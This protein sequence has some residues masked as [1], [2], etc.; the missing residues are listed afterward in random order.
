MYRKKRTYLYL[1]VI[2]TVT[3]L[4]I[5][6][7]PSTYAL[8]INQQQ[9][10]DNYIIVDKNNGDFSSIQE[11]I[12]YA[13]SGSTIYVKKGVYNEIIDVYKSI[14]L[15]GEDKESTLINPVS[16][17]N[18]YAVSLGA[19]NIKL[20]NF[21][22]KNGAPGLYASALKIIS[23]YCEIENCDLFE[24][25]IGISI[26]SS[27]NIIKNCEFWNCTDEGI[28][29][30]GWMDNG[31]IQNTIENCI[32]RNNCDGIELQYASQNIIR[33][34]EFFDNTH[35]GIDAIAS[36]N[37]R[38]Q[39]IDCIIKNNRVN[40]IYLSSSFGNKIIDCIVS[41]NQDGNIVM[42]KYSLNNQIINNIEEDNPIQMIQSAFQR[43]LNLLEKKNFRLNSFLSFTN[44]LKEKI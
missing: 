40:G 35:T 31:C 17:K 6:F 37:N 16:E 14:S 4:L 10:F 18:K 26:F 15:L 21:K 5:S 3:F 39:I 1:T 8:Q 20:K 34:C 32:F 41:D 27:G 7:Y 33:N 13:T 28:A 2:A 29:L 24:T 30:L 11:A 12:D 42:N 43:I 36:L 23:S 19:Q 25:P 38:N 44:F 22:I 9:N